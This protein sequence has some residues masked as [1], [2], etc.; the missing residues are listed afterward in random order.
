MLV[1]FMAI[2]HKVQMCPE[3]N[4][5]LTIMTTISWAFTMSQAQAKNW[6]RVRLVNHG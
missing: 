5:L 2:R 6:E 1:I 4:K 3:A